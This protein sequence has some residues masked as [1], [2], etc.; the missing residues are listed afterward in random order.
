MGISDP[1]LIKCGVAIWLHP[2][3]RREAEKEMA[4]NL[5][6]T[7]W[8]SFSSRQLYKKGTTKNQNSRTYNSVKSS[9]LS[10]SVAKPKMASCLLSLISNQHNNAKIPKALHAGHAV[11]VSQHYLN[12]YK[13]RLLG[14]TPKKNY[15]LLVQV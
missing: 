9:S 6:V 5:C 1:F 12:A 3:N 10:F 7:C 15:L 13:F 14:K 4:H 11:F 8:V 2:I